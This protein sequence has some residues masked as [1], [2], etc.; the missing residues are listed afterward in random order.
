[1]IEQDE[2]TAKEIS[3][4]L[5]NLNNKRKLLTAQVESEAIGIIESQIE[6]NNGTLP[7]ILLVAKEDWHEGVVGIVA[8]KLKEKYN[9]PTCIISINENLCKGSGRSIPG[10]S[11]GDLFQKAVEEK[12]LLKGGGH[13]MAAG[14]SIKKEKIE[15]FRTF[16]NS[17]LIKMML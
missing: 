11:L 6:K 2:D 12:L 4:K 10:V 15:A 7:N 16:L 17:N 5:D 13:D 14:L 3:I 9:R 1:M 8:S